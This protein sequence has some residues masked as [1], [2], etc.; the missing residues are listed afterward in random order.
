V[1][2]T[3]LSL[4][5]KVL[6]GETADAIA[7][8]MHLFNQRALPDLGA[9]IRCGNSLVEDDFYGFFQ[10]SFFTEDQQHKINVFT[11]KKEFPIA[12]KEECGFDIVIGNPPYGAELLTEEKEYLLTHYP[13]QTYQLDTYLLFLER[14]IGLLLKKGGRLGMIIPNPWLTNVLQ[15]K[16]R[17]Y[18]LSNSTINEIMHFTFPVFAKAKA[19]VDTEIV[20]LQ[21]GSVSGLNPK[22]FI[23]SGLGPDNEIDPSLAKVIDQDQSVWRKSASNAINIFLSKEERRLA[24]KIK[25]KG[26]PIGLLFHIS[27]GMKPYQVGKG[28]PKQKRDDVKNRVF[29]SDRRLSS[30]YRQYIRGADILRFIVAPLEAR[31]IRY[32]EWLAE[33]RPT[34]NF[35]AT[36]K[37]VMR[38]TGDSLIA[39]IDRSQLICMNNMHVLVPNE[40]GHNLLYYLGLLNSRL[41]NWY[42]QSLNPEMGEA[43]A[44]VK[45]TNVERL[46]VP[47]MPNGEAELVAQF[48]GQIQKDLIAITP[49]S[50]ERTRTM[51]KRRIDAMFEQLNQAV[52]RLY[53]LTPSEVKAIESTQVDISLQSR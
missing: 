27:V 26:K 30:V 36:E 7:A 39:A 35:E 31:Y 33:P 10:T 9:N 43:L 14:S 23:V 34:A 4:L 20:V 24:N 11:W 13:H 45:K 17:N 29:D 46:P 8:Q 21:K 3:K 5:L 38:Q 22:V 19:T 47:V 41:M 50:A 49:N 18:I 16:I 42:Y 6:E 51:T 37:I 32:G 2:V 15:T 1:E 12:F 25:A 48:A 52:Y 40:S 28:T 53:E 44:E